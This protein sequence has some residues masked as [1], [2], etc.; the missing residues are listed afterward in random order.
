MIFFIPFTEWY[1]LPKSSIKMLTGY[2]FR[3]FT[4]YENSVGIMKLSIYSS[5]LVELTVCALFGFSLRC[6]VPFVLFTLFTNNIVKH[7]RKISSGSALDAFC[8]GIFPQSLPAV[9][10]WHRSPR[11]VP[12][13]QQSTAYQIYTSYHRN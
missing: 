13:E 5:C 2:I 11:S 8:N 6:F 9:F 4:L 1:V 7:K 3:F 12:V 10:S